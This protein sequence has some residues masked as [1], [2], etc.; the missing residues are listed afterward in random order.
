MA[1]QIKYSCGLEMIVYSRICRVVQG[2]TIRFEGTWEQCRAW[3]ADC[4][5]REI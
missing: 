5:A 1:Y 2:Q 4:G 3:L